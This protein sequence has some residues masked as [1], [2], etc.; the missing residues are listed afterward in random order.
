MNLMESPVRSGYDAM[1]QTPFIETGG[2]CLLLHYRF[3]GVAET[4]LK[5]T[6]L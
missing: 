1:L 2:K 3:L 5:I 4:T 6:G